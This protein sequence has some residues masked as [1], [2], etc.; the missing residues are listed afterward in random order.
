MNLE[1]FVRIAAQSYDAGAETGADSRDISRAR[2]RESVNPPIDCTAGA[3]AISID[4]RI[5]QSEVASGSR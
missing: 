4:A 3:I 2:V 5:V 1:I